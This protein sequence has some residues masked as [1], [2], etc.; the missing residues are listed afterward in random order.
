MPNY[1]LQHWITGV[2]I[3]GLVLALLEII[4][5]RSK[6]A[7]QREKL[8]MF[9]LIA[10]HLVDLLTS[11]QWNADLIMNEEFGKLKISQLQ[12]MDKVKTSIDD[13]TKLVHNFVNSTGD[14]RERSLNADAKHAVDQIL[15]NAASEKNA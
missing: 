9:N 13:A 10:H 6:A 15:E 8:V 12:I 11:V 4:R 1:V 5:L 14:T 7:K 2:L 3:V